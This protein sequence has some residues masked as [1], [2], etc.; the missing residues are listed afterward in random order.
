LQNNQAQ[1]KLNQ[2]PQL[3]K[4]PPPPS[5]DGDNNAASVNSSFNPEAV[6]NLLMGNQASSAAGTHKRPH[7]GDS[8]DSRPAAEQH[9]GTDVDDDY[10]D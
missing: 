8:E 7:P 6:S 1:L 10:Y 3:R 5:G 2:G 9:G 4:P